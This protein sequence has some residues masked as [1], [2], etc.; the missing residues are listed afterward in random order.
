M[1]EKMY[2]KGAE[3]NFLLPKRSPAIGTKGA[4]ASSHYL[5]TQVGQ[6]MLKKGGHAVDAV[7]A[8]NAVLAVVYPHMAG[9]G[10]D[11][12][13]MIHDK[14]TG[15]IETI[16]GSGASGEEA[17]REYYKEKG[18]TDKIPQRGPL[19]ANTVP[20]AV[21][22]WWDMHQKYGKLE[23]EEILEPARKY[24]E[25]GFPMSQKFV[26]YLYG[27]QD[28]LESYDEI[29]RIFLEKNQNPREGDILKQP[30][31]ARTLQKIMDGGA[32]A[33]YKGEIAKK[34]VADLREHGGMLT[35]D[36]FASY[37]PDWEEALTTKY[38][39][40]DVYEMRPNTQGLTALIIMN[41]LEQFDM[42][43]IGDNTADYYHVMA[44][45]TKLAFIYKNRFITDSTKMKMKPEELVSPDLGKQLAEK[46]S[47]DHVTPGLVEEESFPLFQTSRDTTYFAAVDEEGNAVSMI[48]SI[49]FEFGSGF[50]PK[51]T[52][53]I[54]QNRGSFFS[55][56]DQL[57]NTLEPR[58]KTFH[59]IMPAMLMQNNKPLALLGTMGGE[60]QP[61]TQAAMITRMLD[62]GY[63][64]QEAIEAPRWLFGRTWG[65]ESN[66]FKVEKRI[67]DGVIQELERRGQEMEVLAEY[68]DTMGHAQG[69]VIN[70]ETGVL[71]AGA[72][73]R[74]DGSAISW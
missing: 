60:G 5:A 1:V 25:E 14:K 45:A 20:G 65:S 11:A 32:D 13:I 58:K 38:R 53:F 63:N 10:G 33:F 21:G 52:G 46:I 57:A 19:A 40:V 36:D 35:E 56:D 71:S 23:W 49:Y 12:M 24:A 72:D 4:V 59:T 29:N 73:P 28:L 22:A 50:M 8:L 44:E 67:S 30:E 16:N 17:T 66:T 74:G 2:K 54:L 27:K 61:Q 18:Y 6:D 26:N 47:L 34:V 62:F 55:L 69:I 48:Q 43:S 70:Q 31:L 9:L 39:D 37:K 64:I 7:I 3:L 51:D 41:I 42:Q 15:K 68:S